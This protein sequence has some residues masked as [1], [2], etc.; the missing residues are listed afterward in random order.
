M[1]DTQGGMCEAAANTC[2]Y[3]SGARGFPPKV[4]QWLQE[5]WDVVGLMGIFMYVAGF[6]HSGVT[7]LL[8]LFVWEVPCTESFFFADESLPTIC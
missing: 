1:V 5:F 3:L 7:A 8:A 4:R 2:W 6:T